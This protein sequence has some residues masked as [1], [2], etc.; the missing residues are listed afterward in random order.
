MATQKTWTAEDVQMEEIKLHLIGT[1]LSAI[2]GYHFVD[3][4]G[5]EIEELPKG[6][7]MINIEFADLPVNIRTA[8]T[9]INTYM[10]QVA[11]TQEGM[12]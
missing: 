7:A 5:D 3:G 4:S 11:L 6:T 8:L 10:Y 1:T 12:E 2:Q 9:D